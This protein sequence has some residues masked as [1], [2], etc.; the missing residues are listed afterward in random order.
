LQIL[1]AQSGFPD[2]TIDTA[3]TRRDASVWV[4]F[5]IHEGE[6][7]RIKELTIDGVGGIVPQREL[8]RVLPL[9]V[10]DPFDRFLLR[11]STDTIVTRLKN[12]GYP[13]VDVFRSFEVDRAARTADVTF[14]VEPGARAT[15]AA[16]DVVGTE[17]VPAGVVRRLIPLRVGRSFRLDDIYASQRDLYRTGIY[18]YADVQLE[19]SLPEGPEDSLV[20]IRVRVREGPLQR[21]RLG[22][23]YGTLDCFRTL[24]GWTAHHLLGGARTLDI[25][26]RL[27]KI[28]TGSPFSWGLQN[29]VCKSLSSE[30]DTARLALNYNV[31]ASVN[32]PVLFSRGTSGTLSLFGERRSELLAYV[33]KGVGGEVSVTRQTRWQVPLTF[34]YRLERGSTKAAPASFCVYFNICRQE[35]IAVF[36]EP[37]LQAT[38]GVLAVRNRQDPPLNP[39]R[40]SLVSGEIQWAAP[41]IGSDTLAKFTRIQAQFAQYLPI[42]RRS[43]LAWR[44]QAGKIF[45]PEQSL[46][47]IPP[48][49]RF[50]GGGPNSVRGYGQNQL[51]PVVR[52]I[53]PVASDTSAR[54]TLTSATGG[55]DLVFANVELRVPLPLF[56]GR[57]QGAV[58]VDGG[59]VYV[60]GSEALRLTDFRVTPGV[61]VRLETALGPVRLDVAYNGYGPT[62]GPLYVQ[63]GTLLD[64][65]QSTFTPPAPTS[66]FQRLQFHFSV[67]QA[68]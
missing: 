66:L 23:G 37:L 32:E 56:S 63:N 62:A 33:R 24:G 17:R 61:G 27:S 26:S 45:S 13:Y 4:R 65:E 5:L 67:G 16:I 19:D 48:G 58:F 68:F 11:A 50:Y 18:D 64:L 12:R 8:L 31:T 36:Q 55:N 9:Q 46:L 43:V 40:G 14:Q 30:P 25:T 6:P 54:D 52:V 28:G 35:D 34:S 21:I 47:S 22:A 38:L 41:V 10:G 39:L 49:E 59:Q 42:G 53:Q 57:L 7:I 15:V 3:V 2:A 44:V 1:Y 51:G 29:N 60:R 20:T